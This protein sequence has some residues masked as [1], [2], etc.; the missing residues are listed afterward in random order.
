[1]TLRIRHIAPGI[2]ENALLAACNSRGEGP[3][4]YKDDGTTTVWRT[5]L[6]GQPCVVKRYN[7]KNPWHFLRRNFQVSRALNCWHMA[8]VF[9]QAGIRVAPPLGAVE[10]SIGP[11]NGRSWYVSDFVQGVTLLELVQQLVEAGNMEAELHTLC[12]EIAAFFGI[13]VDHRLSHGDLKATNILAVDDGLVFLDLDAARSHEDGARHHKALARD[14]WRFMKN[15][16]PWPEIHV[17]FERYLERAGI[18][19]TDHEEP[20]DDDD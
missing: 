10:E 5:L 17:L 4:L 9:R 19:E 3:D 6:D 1:M 12:R 11:L 18:V 2:G 8:E 15:W 20:E 7:T 16:R 13:L 14:R